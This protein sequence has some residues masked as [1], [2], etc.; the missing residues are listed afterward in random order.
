MGLFTSIGHSSASQCT[1]SGLDKLSSEIGRVVDSYSTGNV[2][3]YR[4]HTVNNDDTMEDAINYPFRDALQFWT[5]WNGP[6]QPER[7]GW[8][9]LS[10]VFTS[11]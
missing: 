6:L 4:L 11:C 3:D 8:K 7:D 2:G 1:C 10:I 9:H 5:L